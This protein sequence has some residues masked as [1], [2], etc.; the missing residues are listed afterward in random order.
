MLSVICPNCGKEAPENALFCT[1]CGTRLE[2]PPAEEAPVAPVAEVAAAPAEESSAPVAEAPVAVPAADPVVPA[3]VAE[4][5][6]AE[7]PVAVPI[8]DPVV[9]VPAQPRRRTP[10]WWKVIRCF[11]SIPL[12]AVLT[13]LLIGVIAMFG[14]QN[15]TRADTLESMI[16]DMNIIDTIAEEMSDGETDSLAEALYDEY[17]EAAVNSDA[18][19]ILTESELTEFIEDSTIEDFIA[20]KGSE[21]LSAFLSGENDAKITEDELLDLIKDNEKVIE[22]VTGGHTLTDNDYAMIEDFIKEENLAEQF[23]MSKMGLDEDLS[24]DMSVVRTVYSSGMWLLIGVSLFVLL[25]I[26]LFNLCGR[27]LTALYSG[28]ALLIAGGFGALT[29]VAQSAVLSM[30]RAEMKDTEL[31]LI[32][33]VVETV[34]HGFWVAG[35]VALAAGAACII[36]FAIVRIISRKK[37]M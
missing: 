36:L 5:P 11:F 29:L 20:E 6:V 18:D 19:I 34:F 37:R 16:K 7:A 30:A 1:G 27:C 26:A 35:L 15:L 28:I 14:L 17:Y 12:T 33:P 23:D 24:E 3:P 31:N 4:T 10:T 2:K 9:P 32:K 8:A 25:L 13:V 21:F 22:K